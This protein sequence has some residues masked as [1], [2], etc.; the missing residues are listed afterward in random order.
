MATVPRTVDKK[1]PPQRQIE[2][3]T[4]VAIGAIVLAVLVV[5][6]EWSHARA[7]EQKREQLQM[8][9]G[10]PRDGN[11]GRRT[12]GAPRDPSAGG[13]AAGAGPNLTYGAAGAAGGAGGWRHL[14][15][16]QRAARRQKQIDDMAKQLGLS[17]QQKSQV[18]QLFDQARARQRALR[19][20]EAPREIRQE[21]RMRDRVDMETQMSHILT[22]DQMN[23]FHLMRS[24]RFQRRR[25]SGGGRR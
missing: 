24:E 16:E 3:R 20:S 18:Q 21:E 4:A 8:L 17:E 22:Q 25:D 6:W 14:S 2:P 5:G 11:R 7:V 9:M 13:Q 23:Q 10:G 15:P 1:A 12:A 19:E